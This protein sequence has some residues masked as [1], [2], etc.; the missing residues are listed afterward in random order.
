M[1][2]SNYYNLV[3][4]L[5]YTYADV[6]SKTV[7]ICRGNHLKF[8]NVSNFNSASELSDLFAYSQL[9]GTGSRVALQLFLRG[10]DRLACND[11]H[12]RF[13]AANAY[14]KILRTGTALRFVTHELL[15]DTILQ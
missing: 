15:D 12:L 6:H 1:V 2:L 10:D 3:I 13:F 11:I 7:Q 5:L 8:H 9:C 4:I 14:R